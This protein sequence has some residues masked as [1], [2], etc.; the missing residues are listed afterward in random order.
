MGILGAVLATGCAPVVASGLVMIIFNMLIL[1]I[2]GNTGV[3]A[4]FNSEGNSIMQR[5][6]VESL[7]LYF[8]SAPFVGY[9]IVSAMYFTASEKALPAQILSL[10]R[11]FFIAAALT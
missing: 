11:G 2:Q 10:M 6:A 5:M 9:N 3:A 8:L 7:K 4:V 1:R